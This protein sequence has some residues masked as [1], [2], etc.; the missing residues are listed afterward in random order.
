MHMN[1]NLSK[2]QLRI[3]HACCFSPVQD[4]WLKSIQNG[5]F[6]TW[7]SLTVDNVCKYLPKYDTMFKGYM[8]RIRQHIRS[9]QTAVTETKPEMVQEDK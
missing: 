9:K 1:K 7:S 8:N 6:A 5:H 3:F 4:T 2:T